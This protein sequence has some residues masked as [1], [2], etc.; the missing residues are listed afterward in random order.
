MESKQCAICGKTFPKKPGCSLA[1]W[2]A[3]R[4]CSRACVS[5]WQRQHA[6]HMPSQL[7]TPESRA[8][9]FNALRKYW[10]EHNRS[11]TC[12][13][14]GAKFRPNK[15]TARFC[16][17]ACRGVWWS[18]H[19]LET[20][21]CPGCGKP[22]VRSF[23]RNRIKRYCSRACY[24]ANHSGPDSPSWKGG[25]EIYYGPEWH[26]LARAIR[27]RDKVCQDCGKTPQENGRSLEVHHIA[28]LREFPSYVEANHP[29]NL[30]ALCSQCHR[31]YQQRDY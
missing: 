9:A 30:K 25:P 16:S 8:K 24:L 13:I 26:S 19:R 20:A 12:E 1:Q 22:F 3:M 17:R 14:C 28:P 31:K 11:A 2:A 21:I 6:N 10:D 29:S 18:Q 15:P 4:F 23:T 27:R 7:F 5:E